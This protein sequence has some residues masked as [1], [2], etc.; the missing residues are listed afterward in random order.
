MAL[1]VARQ[2][3]WYVVLPWGRFSAA[4]I[5]QT[6]PGDV[7]VLE[8]TGCGRWLFKQGATRVDW[9]AEALIQLEATP[10]DAFARLPVAPC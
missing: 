9:R 4:D 10:R 5:D 8:Y 3:P 2:H 6:F 7:F 1:H